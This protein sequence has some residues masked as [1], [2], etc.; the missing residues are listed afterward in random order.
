MEREDSRVKER[1]RRKVEGTRDKYIQK[2]HPTRKQT[3]GN[4]AA[5]EYYLDIDD[6][7][8][9][10][11]NSA[12]S[13]VDPMDRPAQHRP[14]G[15]SGPHEHFAPQVVLEQLGC[16]K[17]R[18]HAEFKL[19][20]D[21]CDKIKELARQAQLA[22]EQMQGRLYLYSE[23]KLCSGCERT[24][25]DFMKMYPCIEVIIFWGASSSKTY[26]EE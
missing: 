5:Y 1:L 19:L 16:P 17:N 25:V 21:C 11:A 13:R 3:T 8:P 12:T 14:K 2:G 22:P 26:R 18:E 9:T 24:L 20:N 23:R 6:K 4:S 7:E 10:I 15:Y